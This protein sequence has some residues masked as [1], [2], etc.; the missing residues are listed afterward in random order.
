MSINEK[1][2]NS[3]KMLFG[4]NLKKLRESKGLSQFELASTM[5]DIASNS[6]I[7]KTT[8]SRIENGRTNVTLSTIIKLAL[9]LEVELNELFSFNLENS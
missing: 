1:K 4:D 3:Y 8:I 6:K 2:I 5:N 7:D 9:A